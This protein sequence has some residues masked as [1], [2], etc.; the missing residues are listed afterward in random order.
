MIIFRLAYRNIKGAGLRTWLN[1][2]V[3]SFIYVLIIWHQG[4]FTGMYEQ[5]TRA[6]IEEEIAGGQYW[7]EDYDPFDPLTIDDSHSAVPPEITDN[8][9]NKKAVP[10]LIR[11]GAIYPAGRMQSVLIRGID[12]GQTV[13]DMPTA[14]LGAEEKVLPV[15]I[16][17]RMAKNIQ[18]NIGDNITIRWRD[19]HGTFDAVEGEVVEIM[20]TLVPG[21]DKGQLW[22]PIEKL[23]E[24]TGLKDEATVI[25]VDRDIAPRTD[26][27]NWVF[28]DHKFLLRDMDEMIMSK[29]VGG[30]I[31]YVILLFL[32]LLAIFDTQILS[33]FRRRKEIGT[34]ISLGMTRKHVVSLFTLEGAMHGI[35]AAAAAAVYGAPFIYWFAKTGMGFPVET[36]EEYGFALSDRIFPIYSAGLILITVFIVMVTVTIV[37]YLPSRKISKLNPT[38]ALKGKIA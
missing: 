23:R 20:R 27:N 12:P 37:S 14:K 4:L 2:A 28:R 13:L 34:L 26:M 18:L 6:V 3:L 24:M 29:R 9:Q 7:H 30:S 25:V 36:I 15:L 38:E 17:Q 11:Q 16:G 31:M 22:V 19:V 8:I 21:I 10:V 33:I 5:G 1:V 35:L 32:A